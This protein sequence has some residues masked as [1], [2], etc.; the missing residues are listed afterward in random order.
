MPGLF[1][2][3]V[4]GFAGVDFQ[5]HELTAAQLRAAVDALRARGVAAIF[6]T[7]ITDTIERLATQFARIESYRAADPVIAKTIPGYHLEGPWLSPEPGYRGAHPAE[8]MRAPNAADFARLQDAAGGNIRLVTLAPEW[9]GSAEFIATL[10]AQGVHVSIGH[11]NATAAQIDDAIRA[12]A[13]FCTHLGNGAP[14]SLP[15]HDNIIQRLLARD[16]LT[17]CFIPDGIHLPPFVL[18]NFVRAKPQGKILFTTDCMAAAGAPPG[19]YTLGSLETLVGGDLIARGPDG[20]FAGSTLTP[21]RGVALTAQYLGIPT[22]EARELW[23][24]KAA[25]A[26]GASASIDIP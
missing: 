23:S 21:D 26:F 20:G 9:P 14:Q 2:F 11:S 10:A 7:L 6:L 16:E 15:R 13:R 19:R 4:N 3:Q 18:K 22:A 24:T 5:R 8:P 1:D 17:A 12:G 25:A